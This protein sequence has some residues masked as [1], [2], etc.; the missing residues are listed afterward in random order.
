M[1]PLLS[2]ARLPIQRCNPSFAGGYNCCCTGVVATVPPVTLSCAH[3]MPAGEPAP[4]HR[5]VWFTQTDSAPPMFVY[6]A[7]II[8]RSSS[9]SS[10]FPGLGTV[11]EATL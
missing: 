11:D 9:E 10:E 1:S 4:Q 8:R 3:W 2:T 7:C 5:T 6:C